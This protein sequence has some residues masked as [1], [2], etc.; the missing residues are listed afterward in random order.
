MKNILF[1]NIKNKNANTETFITV[2]EN[3]S[4][5]NQTLYYKEQNKMCVFIK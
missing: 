3:V 2:L 5:N 4:F 1:S